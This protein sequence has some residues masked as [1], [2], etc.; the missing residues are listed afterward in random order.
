MDEEFD[1]AH[2]EIIKAIESLIEMGL[3]EVLGIN[4]KGEWLYGATDK[5]KEVVESGVFVEI[6]DET[7]EE[8][9]IR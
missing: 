8:D 5:G 3:V 7:I 6:I 2:Q 4:E 9:D 1:E